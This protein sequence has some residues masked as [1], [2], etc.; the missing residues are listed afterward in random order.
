M[1][2]ALPAAATRRPP[3]YLVLPA[4]AAAVG[5]VLPILYLI[6]R[7]L[8]AEPQQLATLI[9]RS[10][11]LVLFGN[12]I[13]LTLGVLT[14]CA[15]LALPLAWLTVRSDIK[16]K[17]LLTFMGVLPLAIPGYVMAYSLISLGG[18]YGFLARIFDWVVPR[19]RGYMG[20]LAALTLYTYPYLFLNLRA[21]FLGLDP[22]LEESSRS[23]GYTSMQT[24]LHVTLPHLKPAFLAGGV[25]ISLYVLGDFGAV[26]LMRFEVFSYA[27]YTQYSSAFNRVYAA[28]LSLMLLTMSL[29]V[30]LLEGRLL[31]R[32]KLA[33]VATGVARKG[34]SVRLGWWRPATYLYLTLLF[35]ASLGLPAVVL[36]YWL[37]LSPPSIEPLRFA[38]VFMRSAAASAPAAVV[39]GLFALPIAYIRIRYP[40]R[41]SRTIERLS[42]VGYAIPPLALAL[43]MVFFSLRSAPWLYQTLPLL[44]L[45]Y[46]LN[47]LALAIGPIRSSLLQSSPRLEEAARSLGR[48]RFEAFVFTVLPS[49]R[50]GILAGMVLVFVIAMKE[51]PITFLLAPTGYLTLSVSVFGRTSEAL[52]AEAAPY[53]AAIV[54]FSSLFVGLMLKYEGRH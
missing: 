36:T 40:S 7:A 53:A 27:I 28:W 50:R 17:R 39:A 52:L 29:S 9:L 11:N 8:D 34:R 43:A 41:I 22:A 10:R 16:H 21:A 45:A 13:A 38:G 24:F 2:P 12:T 14:A 18:N 51:L 23:L 37:T 26:A 30:V 15:V 49:L 35:G 32:A 33:R 6:L 19:P 48:T 54:V 31:G 1:N 47:F 4:G 20:A 25:V 42:Y 5:T 3:W 46:S 44:V